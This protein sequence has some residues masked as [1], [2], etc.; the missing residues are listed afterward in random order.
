MTDLA[1]RA[2]TRLWHGYEC[3][4][5]CMGLGSLGL[6]CIIWLPFAVLF[7]L[8]LPRRL[9]Q[10]VG[11]GVITV[12]FRFYL[13]IL[14]LLCGCRFDLVALK[15]LWRERSIIVAANHPSLLDAVI[16]L[17][18]LPNA[19]CVMKASLL[20][21]PLFGPAARLANYVRNAGALQMFKHVHESLNEGAQAV[22]FPEGTR[23]VSFPLNPLGVTLGLLAHRTRAPVQTVFL[24]Y[25]AP[26][27]GKHWPL[28]RPPTLP[29]HCTARLGRR[30][31]PPDDYLAFT[32]QLERYFRSELP[33]ASD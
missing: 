30:F 28:W 13:G 12:S 33:L 14:S 32:R 5:M 1:K 29:L 22:L 3:A 19:V 4:A 15:P 31:D 6:M 9:G 21:N 18:Y 25:S 20:D 26:Y 10:H 11:R 16:L 24:D 27:L 2:G 17:A 23:T 7:R 8:V